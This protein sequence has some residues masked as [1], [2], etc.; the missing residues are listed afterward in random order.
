MSYIIPLPK[1]YMIAMKYFLI[2]PKWIV[3]R[4][5]KPN[6]HSQLATSNL[7]FSRNLVSIAAKTHK[8]ERLDVNEG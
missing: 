6:F 8:N 5:I 7:G 3:S 4:K 2:S 1:Y